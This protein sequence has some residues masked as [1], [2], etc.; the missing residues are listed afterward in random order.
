M[1]VM[2]MDGDQSRLCKVGKNSRRSRGV[3]AMCCENPTGRALPSEV[4]R[5]L[6]AYRGR[7]GL[8]VWGDGGAAV[9]ATV[10]QRAPFLPPEQCL[11]LVGQCI[12]HAGGDVTPDRLDESV[13]D[14]PVFAELIRQSIDGDVYSGLVTSS[15]QGG[16]CR[17]AQPAR[18]LRPRRSTGAR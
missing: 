3:K 2:G 9:M 6:L 8:G 14:T 4:S 1:S 10:S 15:H 16:R 13:F 7:K 12:A 5:M 17:G 11:P 18:T